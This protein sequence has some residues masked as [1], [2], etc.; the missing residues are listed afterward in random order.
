MMG[1]KHPPSTTIIKNNNIWSKKEIVQSAWILE[2][3]MSLLDQTASNRYVGM[4]LSSA[5]GPAI[6]LITT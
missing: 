5:W 6:G 4:Q 3:V 1:I 2:S